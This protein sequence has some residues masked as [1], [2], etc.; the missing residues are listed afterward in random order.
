MT[1]SRVGPRSTAEG[2]N[3]RGNRTWNRGAHCSTYVLIV[4]SSVEGVGSQSSLKGESEYLGGPGTTE[5]GQI[6]GTGTS[7][8]Q[9]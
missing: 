9:S 7:H 5:S 1:S 2:Q 3:M 6:K 8:E 4:I